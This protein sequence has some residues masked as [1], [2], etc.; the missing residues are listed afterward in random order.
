MTVYAF[1]ASIIL[2]LKSHRHAASSL[3]KNIITAICIESCVKVLI[4]LKSILEHSR[5]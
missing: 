5:S 2:D 1:S 4:I 3:I